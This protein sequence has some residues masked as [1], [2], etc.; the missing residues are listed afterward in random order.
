MRVIVCG[1]RGFDDYDLMARTLD[2]L[3]VTEVAEGGASGAD[4]MAEAW[5]CQRNKPCRTYPAQWA[6]HGKSAGPLRNQHMLD[7]FTPDAVIAFPGGRGTADMVRRA[8]SAGVR[9]VEVW[10]T[11]APSA[12]VVEGTP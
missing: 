3:G 11:L 6:K 7:D 12:R 9:V 10:D 4:D 2:S 5:A 8:K 1:G